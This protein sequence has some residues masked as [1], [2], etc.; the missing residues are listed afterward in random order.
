MTRK[1]ASI[2]SCAAWK[3]KG[4][5]I[6]SDW[7]VVDDT[8]PQ[9]YYKMSQEREMIFANLTQ[10]WQALVAVLELGASAFGLYMAY[11]TL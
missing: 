8:R 6:E 4:Y 3:A 5:W 7:Q 1:A 2:P 10:E 9:R 11:R